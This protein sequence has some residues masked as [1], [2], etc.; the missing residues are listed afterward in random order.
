IELRLPNGQIWSPANSDEVS[1]G[2]VALLDAL[3]HSYNQ[4]TVRVGM[5]IGVERLSQ[6]MEALSGIRPSAHPSLL[7][8]AVYLSPYP[9]TQLYQFLASGGQVQPLRSLRGVIDADGVALNRYD[10]GAEPAQPGD[11]LAA[12]L[13]GVALQRAVTEGTARRLQADGLGWLRSAGKTGTSN[14]SRDSWFAGYTGSHLAT[15]WIGNDDNLPTGLYG[16][17]GA[18]RVWSALFADLPTAP[19]DVGGEGLEWAWVDVAK[20]ARTDENCPDAR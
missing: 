11:A 1:H 19:L 6:L 3:V 10:A 15:V 9:L 8:G 7:L 2:E 16:A 18:M 4:A 14:D 5:D 20:A 12:R 17:S 13:V